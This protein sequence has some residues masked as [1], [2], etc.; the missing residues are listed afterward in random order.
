MALHHSW[1]H[2]TLEVWLGYLLTAVG[3]IPASV[4]GLLLINRGV[5]RQ[6]ALI[7]SVSVAVLFGFVGERLVDWRSSKPRPIMLLGHL[8]EPRKL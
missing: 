5:G 3:A 8:D 4:L 7:I 1:L 2:N 6:L